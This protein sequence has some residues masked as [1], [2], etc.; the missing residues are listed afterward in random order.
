MS[1]MAGRAGRRDIKP[2]LKQGFPVHA[3]RIILQDMCLG[4][5]T[6]QG[7]RLSF[8]MTRAANKWHIERRDIG[9]LV[10]NRKDIVIAVAINTT[11]CQLIPSR[12]G[13]AMDT[14]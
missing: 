11:G 9:M 8:A 7:N 13:L 10:F 3:V 1:A 2:F 6:L 12:Q 5:F 4:N 14:V